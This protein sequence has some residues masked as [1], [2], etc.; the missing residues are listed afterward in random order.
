MGRDVCFADLLLVYEGNRTIP[1]KIIILKPSENRGY[2][3]NVMAILIAT[4]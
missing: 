3:K 4:K 2:I 1:R